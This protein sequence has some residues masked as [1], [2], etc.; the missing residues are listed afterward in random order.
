MIYENV[1]RLCEKHKTNI[2]TVEKACGIAN[3]TIGKWAGK[4]AAPR[5]DT[6]KAIA[7]YFGVSLDY[8]LERTDELVP[9]KPKKKAEKTEGTLSLVKEAQ[10]KKEET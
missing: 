2:A 7:D 1:K 6:V 5:I 10:P 8:L 9:F 4:D 3:G